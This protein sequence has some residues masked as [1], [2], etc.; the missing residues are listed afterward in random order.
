MGKGDLRTKRGKIFRGSFGK[1]R[2]KNAKKEKSQPQ[3]V[4]KAI[5]E[6]APEEDTREE[7]LEESSEESSEETSEETS[8]E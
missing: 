1:Y 2:P 6:K 3:V 5:I 4:E 8:E 7:L